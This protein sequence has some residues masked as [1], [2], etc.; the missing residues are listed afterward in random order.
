MRTGDERAARRRGALK[1][2]P[3]LGSIIL[4]IVLAT[5]IGWQAVRENVDNERIAREAR[6]ES[7]QRGNVNR[8]SMR[9]SNTIL[10]GLLEAALEPQ[11]GQYLAARRSLML[12]LRAHPDDVVARFSLEATRPNSNARRAVAS[13][14]R[15]LREQS[16]A[17]A[18]VP[19]ETAAG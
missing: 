16:R 15:L 9:V 1:V 17:L 3:T 11:R 10:S 4:C 8:A 7:C 13:A 12:H 19:C 18:P 14:Q 6:I 2:M 5:W